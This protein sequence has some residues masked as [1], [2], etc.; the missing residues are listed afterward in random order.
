MTECAPSITRLT[1][2]AGGQRLPPPNG[3]G[4]ELPAAREGTRSQPAAARRIDPRTGRPAA[5][6]T[7]RLTKWRPVSSNALLGGKP[8]RE[9]LEQVTHGEKAAYPSRCEQNGEA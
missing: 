6:A 4:I 5:G 8:P 2:L 7:G 9:Q 1:P 3:H